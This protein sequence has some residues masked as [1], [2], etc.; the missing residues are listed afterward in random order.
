MLHKIVTA[1]VLVPL[2]VALVVLAVANRRTVTIAFDPFEPTDPAFSITLPLY[3]LILALIIA[4]VIVGGV[5]AWLRQGKW[6][7]R[8]RA[9]ESQARALR[10]ENDL[11]RRREA[12]IPPPVVAALP[13]DHTPR[14]SIPPPAR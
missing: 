5:A 2:A 12:A 14:L 8:A 13:V 1:L 11:L 3:G 4:G 10:A 9:A 6:R 7:R